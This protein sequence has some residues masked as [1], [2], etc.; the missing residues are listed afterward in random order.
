M[1][2]GYIV[3]D[4]NPRAYNKSISFFFEPIPLDI[5]KILNNEHPFWN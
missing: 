5:G 4:S 1:Q 2:E 3:K